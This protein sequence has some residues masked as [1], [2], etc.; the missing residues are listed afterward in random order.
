MTCKC[1]RPF[2]DEIH[3]LHPSDGHVFACGNCGSTH[4]ATRWDGAEICEGC[5]APIDGGTR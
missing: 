3:T 4:Q 2:D 5:G 1:G